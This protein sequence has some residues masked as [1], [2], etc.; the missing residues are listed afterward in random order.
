MKKR[1]EN[2]LLKV[3]RFD[4]EENVTSDED[5]TLSD[6]VGDNYEEEVEPW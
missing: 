4:M 5:F 6:V 3:L 2:P 1:Y